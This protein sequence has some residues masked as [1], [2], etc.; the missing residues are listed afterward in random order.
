M[1]DWQELVKRRL[2][3][4]AL[5]PHEKAEII[6]EVAAHL[7]D[8]CDAM[9]ERGV[10]ENEA[11]ERALSQVGSW[12]DLQNR[13]HAT[14]RSKYVMRNRFRQLWVPGFLTMIL[15]LLPIVLHERGM[16]YLG[17]LQDVSRGLF[18]IM[19]HKFGFHP[20]MIVTVPNPVFFYAPWLL[21]LVLFGAVGAYVSS[22]AGGSRRTVVLASVFPSLAL[23]GAFLSMFPIGFAIER[24]VGIHED[25]GVVATALL[26]DGVDWIVVPGAALLAGGLAV[27]FLMGRRAP[28]HQLAD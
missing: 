27:Q 15:S 19:L 7:E 24:I 13:I 16:R 22:R 3:K 25:F 20:R 23:T 21:S 5:E 11:V 26:K 28:Q 14:K 4:L 12:R 1:R 10:P 6:V 17:I 9:R 8:A 2:D 18:V